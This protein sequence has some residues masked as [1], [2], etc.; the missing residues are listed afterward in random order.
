[1]E[2]IS[3]MRRGNYASQ[4]LDS[5][6]DL[7][8]SLLKIPVDEPYYFSVHIQGNATPKVFYVILR[9]TSVEGGLVCDFYKDQT[10]Y[11]GSGMEGM[12]DKDYLIKT[13]YTSS[14]PIEDIIDMDIAEKPKVAIKEDMVNY[15]EVFLDAVQVLAVMPY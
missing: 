11:V 4:V 8:E 10:L 2:R 7:K 9:S 5:L 14:A 15:I 12:Y 1:M 13:Y 6:E 3:G